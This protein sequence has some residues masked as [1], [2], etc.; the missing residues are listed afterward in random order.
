VFHFGVLISFSS[1]MVDMSQQRPAMQSD[2]SFLNGENVWE[3]VATVAV[4][5]VFVYFIALEVYS[6]LMLEGYANDGLQNLT[7]ASFFGVVG[8]I[9][10]GAFRGDDSAENPA[11]AAPN[12]ES[13]FLATI[14]LNASHT[15]IAVADT[16]RRIKLCNP[17]FHSLL[18]YSSERDV[19]GCLLQDLLNLSGSDAESLNRCFLDMTT[20]EA[21][22]IFRG[23]VVHLKVSPSENDSESADCERGFIVVLR[24]VTD[25]RALEL[26]IHSARQ[27]AYLTQAILQVIDSIAQRMQPQA[28]QF[29][30]NVNVIPIVPDDE[31][32]PERHD[33]DDEDE[34]VIW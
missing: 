16:E 6:I 1:K 28:P 31:D 29:P 18:G 10:A 17:A 23:R 22:F 21:E 12:A 32:E 24:D 33:V 25:E 26:A 7:T 14:A 20:C 27:Q 15:P 2:G 4:F 11:A 30:L 9:A 34:P 13:Q 3:N 8:L 19:I 5:C